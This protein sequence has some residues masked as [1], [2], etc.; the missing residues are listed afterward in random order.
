M[1]RLIVRRNLGYS[2]DDIKKEIQLLTSE[3]V[4]LERRRKAAR[5]LMR[6]A[7]S[8]DQHAVIIAA[9]GIAAF[10]HALS[11]NDLEICGEAI[12]ALRELA[13]NWSH[14]RLIAEAGGFRSL[15]HLLQ[16]QR[17]RIRLRAASALLEP[18]RNEQNHVLIAEAGGLRSLLHVLQHQRTRRRP[19]AASGLLGPAR[20]EQNHVFM[21]EVRGIPIVC[22]LNDSNDSNDSDGS[23][24]EL[25]KS[26]AHLLTEL[27]CHPENR[28]VISQAIP[29]FI[30]MLRHNNAVERE[31]AKDALVNLSLKNYGDEPKPNMLVGEIVSSLSDLLHHDGNTDVRRRVAR[32]L[33]KI[34]KGC[35]PITEEHSISSLLPLLQ[36]RQDSV[37]QYM[38]SFLGNFL[39]NYE[40]INLLQE[41][42]TA[43]TASLQDQNPKVCEYATD[44]LRKLDGSKPENR[45]IIKEAVLALLAVL[46]HADP[47]R[48]KQAA[49]V[50]RGLAQHSVSR[51]VIGEAGGMTPLIR[52]LDDPDAQVCTEAAYALYCL[53]R[54]ERNLAAITAARGI[55]PF[56]AFLAD[57]DE[58]MNLRES[59]TIRQLLPFLAHEETEVRQQATCAL[60]RLGQHDTLRGST[61]RE[62][63]IQAPR[64]LLDD[65]DARL[66]QRTEDA[67]SELESD[68][69]GLR[70]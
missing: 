51:T 46:D 49:N 4:G 39:G 50:L 13:N 62:G 59:E 67:S 65:Q 69:L 56:V 63:D 15:I 66:R 36:D 44:A 6:L 22:F 32:I 14:H 61:E 12:D 26:A 35:G 9:G 45:E 19:H 33:F 38:A 2:S 5:V 11:D 60:E 43:L 28:R 42:V 47:K 8:C 17:T 37:R 21:A 41:T 64:N 30:N 70:R 27:A 23:N 25:R 3:E 7:S 16:H 10:T 57:A 20:N 48:R 31:Q 34:S 52:L 53:G 58:E 68:C 1:R 18:A 54:D 55:G 40:N 24:S 29:T